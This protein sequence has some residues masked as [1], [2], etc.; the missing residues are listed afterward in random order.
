MTINDILK[1]ADGADT[2][3]LRLVALTMLATAEG[4]EMAL[5]TIRLLATDSIQ[6]IINSLVGGLKNE[7]EKQQKEV[8]TYNQI[9]PLLSQV[10]RLVDLMI[11]VDPQT[12]EE[13]SIQHG[14]EMAYEKLCEMRDITGAE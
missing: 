12:G 4:N 1:A 9:N 11:H 3:T 7:S 14:L 8:V 6:A 5:Q 13:D 10:I 2:N